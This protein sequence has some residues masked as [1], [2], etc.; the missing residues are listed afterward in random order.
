MLIV[1]KVYYF[2]YSLFGCVVGNS[3]C[4]PCGD[5]EKRIMKEVAVAEFKTLRGLT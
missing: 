4:I 1:H 5:T 3:N 2:V